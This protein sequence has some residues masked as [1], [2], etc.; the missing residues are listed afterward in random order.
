VVRILFYVIPLIIGVIIFFDLK[1]LGRG[2]LAWL[3]ATACV[4][5]FPVGPMIYMGVRPKLR[6]MTA[7]AATDTSFCSRCGHTSGQ[8]EKKCSQ[9]GNELIL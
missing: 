3:V 4:F 1:K 9:C 6:A 5:L 8:H 2:S 7:R